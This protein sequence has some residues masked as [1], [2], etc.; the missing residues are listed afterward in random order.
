MFERIQPDSFT[1]VR[2]GVGVGVCENELDFLTR[3]SKFVFDIGFD[4]P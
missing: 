2:V 4:I 3:L 1:T